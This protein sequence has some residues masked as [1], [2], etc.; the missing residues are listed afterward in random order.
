MT[1]SEKV[2][3]VGVPD[4][5]TLHNFAINVLL[6]KINLKSVAMGQFSTRKNKKKLQMFK[7]KLIFTQV[8]ISLFYLPLTGRGGGGG[9]G[10]LAIIHRKCLVFDPTGPVSE[11]CYFKFSITQKVF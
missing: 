1:N 4:S 10:S 6:C 9:G 8:H 11:L 7:K 5:G 3:L 2:N